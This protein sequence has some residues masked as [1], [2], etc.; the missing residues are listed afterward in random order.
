MFTQSDYERLW[1]Y[2]KDLE[3]RIE[4]LE[5]NAAPTIPIYDKT[6]FPQDAVEGQIAIA[7]I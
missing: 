3:K 1:R 7:P 4:R 2:A 6:N 5:N